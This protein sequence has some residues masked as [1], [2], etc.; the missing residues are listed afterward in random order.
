MASVN[1]ELAKR[2]IKEELVIILDDLDLSW[3][4]DQVDKTEMMWKSGFSLEYMAKW[5]RPHDNEEDAEDE[6]ALLVMHLKRQGKIQER[7]GGYAGFNDIY[8]DREA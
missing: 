1:A 8:H 5:L 2:D 6:V 7:S 4:K 3:T